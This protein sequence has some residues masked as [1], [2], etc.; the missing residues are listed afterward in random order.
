MC[1]LSS[2][3]SI[4]GLRS[5]ASLKRSAFVG[6][7]RRRIARDPRTQIR[8]L[9]EALQTLA[10]EPELLP[11]RGLRSAA[12]LKLGGDFVPVI[13][14]ATIRGLR[15]AA[16]LKPPTSRGASRGPSSRSADSDPRPH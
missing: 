10:D 6:L 1:G 12:S 3:H 2:A 8:G 4:R 14:E 16:S 15:S 5:A 13:A 11:I 9:I 7:G